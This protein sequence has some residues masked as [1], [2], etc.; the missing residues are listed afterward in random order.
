MRAAAPPTGPVTTGQARPFRP[1][2][3]QRS[4]ALWRNCMQRH[5]FL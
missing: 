5:F 4:A 1:A 3:W 2:Q